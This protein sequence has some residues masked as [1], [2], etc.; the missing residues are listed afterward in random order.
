MLKDKLLT[1]PEEPGCYLMKD[2]NGTVIYVGKAKVLK[3][4]VNS[5]FHGAHNFKTTKLV[6]NIVDFDFIVTGS[7]KEAFILEYNLIKQYKPRFNIQFMDDSSYP[8]IRLTKEKYP[9]L[10]LVRDKKKMKNAIYFGPYP[11]AG[12]AREL[13]EVLNKLYPLRKCK[14]MPTKVCL[15]YHIGLCLGPC[16]YEVDQKQYEQLTDEI[17]S[18]MNGN[19]KEMLVDLQKKRDQYSE[20]LQF[21]KAAD[22]Q[23]LIEAINHVTASQYMQTNQRRDKSYDVFNYYVDKG[24]IAICGLLYSDGKLLHKHQVLKPL[25]DDVEETFTSYLLQYYNHNPLPKILMMPKEIDIASL[26]DVLDNRIVQPI[27]GDKVQLVNL[28]KEN[29]KVNLNQKFDII[30]K[31]EDSTDKAI[32]QLNELLG[33]NCYRIELYDISHT[34]GSEAVA[35]EVVYLNGRQ[36]PKDYRTYKVSNGNDDTG[37]RKE[38]LYR[39]LYRAVREN[40]VLPDLII[41]DGGVNQIHAAKE[42]AD[43]LALSNIE[44]LGL[45]KNDKHSTS[46][47]IDGDENIITIDKQSELFYLLTRMQDEVHRFAISYH[48]RRREKALIASVLDDI[49]GVGTK[50]KEK[51]LKHFGSVNKISQ[52]SIEQLCEVVDKTTAENIYEFFHKENDD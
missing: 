50:R 17:V 33:F 36:S 3:N 28:A 49:N 40:T 32:S 27:R 22:A 21:E 7:E 4:R 26:N 31:Q 15:Y 12:Y 10:S 30:N 13:L 51:L 23:K 38:A 5:Y 35:G 47:L 48:K 1:L 9:T 43:S 39:R 2:K 52:A 29:A 34:A 16:Q 14:N 18:F 42:I 24:Y 37:N 11:N 45:V 8:Y 44:I 19:T 25:Y 41:V 6:Q 46:E 20:D